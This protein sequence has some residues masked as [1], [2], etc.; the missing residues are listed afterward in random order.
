MSQFDSITRA[1]SPND[2]LNQ[3]ITGCMASWGANK[4]PNEVTHVIVTQA[5]P[6]F[7]AVCEA[8]I[9]GFRAMAGSYKVVSLAEF[10]QMR[11][12]GLYSSP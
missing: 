1:G 2:D 8:H 9:V 12:D 4:C 7:C 5:N 6:G 3:P 10:E 11:A